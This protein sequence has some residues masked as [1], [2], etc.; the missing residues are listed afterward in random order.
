MASP[1]TQQPDKLNKAQK[2]TIGVTIGVC[3]LTV[4]LNIV[5]REWYSPDLRYH[6]GDGYYLDDR[7]AVSC[8]IRNRGHQTAKTIR[9]YSSFDSPILSYQ[10][11][12]NVSSKVID[13]G[14]GNNRI[15]LEIDRLAPQASLTVFYSVKQGQTRPFIEKIE[16]EDGLART[17]E[18]KLRYV[19]AI[20][21]SL[22]VAFISVYWYDAA[23]TSRTK[24][25]QEWFSE[26][27]AR[28]KGFRELDKGG[29]G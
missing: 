20:I 5:V 12:G 23:V 13:G 18:P 4:V 6:V 19:I 25:Y 17:G 1:L 27:N 29:K 7:V 2:W 22:I 9:I 10:V 24:A 14:V 16:S 15:T 11:G 28:T 8:E 21:F 3:L 26:V